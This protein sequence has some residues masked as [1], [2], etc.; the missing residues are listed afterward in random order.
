MPSSASQADLHRAKDQLES[1]IDSV[2]LAY[3]IELMSVVCGEK[4]D[5]LESNW[6]DYSAAKDWTKD[7]NRLTMVASK[8]L[9]Q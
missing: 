9:N 2:G 1:I 3:A 4:A 5:H 7:G 6:Q 8:L